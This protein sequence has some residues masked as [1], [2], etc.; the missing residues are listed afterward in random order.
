MTERGRRTL[1]C[2][3]SM[4]GVFKR[5]PCFIID[6]LLLI[7]DTCVWQRR[8]PPHTSLKPSR[9]TTDCS[10]PAQCIAHLCFHERW[11]RHS[12]GVLTRLLAGLLGS[13]E[14]HPRNRGHGVVR[15]GASSA[16]RQ[17]HL[18]LCMAA[19]PII[20]AMAHE[21]ITVWSPKHLPFPC[22]LLLCYCHWK[23]GDQSRRRDPEIADHL[24]RHYAFLSLWCPDSHYM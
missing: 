14:R 2:A 18:H 4:T 8:T 10:S 5:G 1:P 22:P 24:P 19:S 17:C 15:D 20:T 16:I 23:Q 12:T 13:G 6:I 21:I 7:K 9:V 11:F 3:Y